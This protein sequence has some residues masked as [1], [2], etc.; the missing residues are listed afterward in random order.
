M[1]KNDVAFSL[2]EE[3]KYYVRSQN[4]LFL[5]IGRVLK[6]L[7]DS[8][9]YESLGHESWTAFLASGELAIK[10]STAYAYIEI[11][12]VY[13]ERFKY[14]KEDLAEIPYDKLRMALPTAR[15]M[16]KEK[17]VKDLVAKTRELSRRDLMIELGQKKENTP[18]WKTIYI[19]QCPKCKR[20]IRPKELELCKGTCPI[21]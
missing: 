19:L 13:I 10:Q 4:V 12:E 8:N 1:S 9:A 18:N 2:L 15:K 21:Q 5:E 20:W 6:E 17:E 11:Y 7:R 14:N 16:E 3:L